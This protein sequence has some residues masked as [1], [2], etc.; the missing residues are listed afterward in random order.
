MRLKY[1]TINKVQPTDSFDKAYKKAGKVNVKL[2]L[3]F[4]LR[5]N[6]SS[7]CNCYIFVEKYVIYEF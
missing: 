2:F 4:Y 7:R 6:Q 3:L 1:F 5:M